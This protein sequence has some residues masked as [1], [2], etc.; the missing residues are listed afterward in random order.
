[1]KNKMELVKVENGAITVSEEI[2]NK[3]VVFNKKKLEMDL[4]EKELKEK[5]KE[6]MEENNIFETINIGELKISY[7]KSSIRTTVDSKKF[8]EELPDIYEEYSKKSN[9]SSSISLSVE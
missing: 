2:V 7:R 3:I 1:M 8:K 9:V 6:A 4:I 5:I